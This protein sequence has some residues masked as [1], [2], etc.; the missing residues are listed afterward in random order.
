VVASDPCLSGAGIPGDQLVVFWRSTDG[1]MADQHDNSCRGTG[2][3]PGD[4]R[5][6]T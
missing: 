1:L 4:D 2:G 3:A 5:G 6:V